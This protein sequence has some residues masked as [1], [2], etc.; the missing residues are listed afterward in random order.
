MSQGPLGQDRGL[1]PLLRRWLRSWS[2]MWTWHRIWL[3]RRAGAWL[4]RGTRL[5]RFGNR[6]HRGERMRLLLRPRTVRS[7]C[8]RG[9]GTATGGMRPGVANL[10]PWYQ[11]RKLP[12]RVGQSGFRAGAQEALRACHAS[13]MSRP[14]RSS[15]PARPWSRPPCRYSGVSRLQILGRHSHLANLAGKI[16]CRFCGGAGCGGC[17]G[18]GLGNPCSGCGGS[19]LFGGLGN[20]GAGQACGVCG[21]CGRASWSWPGRDRLRALR[22]QGMCELPCRT[23]QRCSWCRRQSERAAEASLLAR[24]SACSITRSSSEVRGPWRAS[25]TD[26]RLRA[27]HSHDPI[28]P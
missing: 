22:R 25:A 21:G 9:C 3:R 5:W 26:P 27:L 2:G 17:G 10:E 4:R 28:S 6:R 23:C 16:R 7:Q 20:G 14:V 18:L 24:H 19:G 13:T 15:R 12:G 8:R 11:W 1:V